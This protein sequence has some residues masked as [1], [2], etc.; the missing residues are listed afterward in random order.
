MVDRNR[1]DGLD[2]EDLRHFTALA[3][4]GSLSAA[5]RALRVN[6]ATVSR[7]VAALEAVLGTVLFERRADGYRLTAEGRATLEEALPM[8][9]AALAVLRRLDRSEALQGAVRLTTT[10]ALAD[11]FLAARL[12]GFHRRHPGIDLEL[13]TDSRRVSLARREAE[14]ALRFGGLKDSDLIVRRLL[15]VEHGFY[16]D[17]AWRERLAAGERPVLIGF[18]ADSGFVPE[19]EWLA[20]AFPA[21]RVAF[22]SNSWAAQ[23]AAARAG[24][25]VALLPR[26][27]AAVADGLEPVSLG[28]EPPAGTL[29][30]LIRPDLTDVP[31]VR[32]LAD[33]LVSLFHHHRA[34]F[35]PGG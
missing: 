10:R 33:F 17:A 20:S 24:F 30:M 5:A 29:S 22:R 2:W 4:A 34:L 8:E 9:E 18:D 21:C 1:T 16:A 15:A 31:R 3:R 32:A 14:I 7:R 19:A 23:A 27:L 6:H 11:D 35:H 28:R 26:Y 12:G 13:V 25:G